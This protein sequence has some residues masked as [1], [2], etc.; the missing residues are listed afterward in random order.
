MNLM[1]C[2]FF[3]IVMTHKIKEEWQIISVQRCIVILRQT[4]I[5][6]MMEE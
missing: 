1:T 6:K 3:N 2:L 4:L 5:G